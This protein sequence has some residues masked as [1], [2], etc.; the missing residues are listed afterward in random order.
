MA[1]SLDAAVVEVAL[2]DEPSRALGEG[3]R[4]DLELVVLRGDEDG[5]TDEVAD[6]MVA[7][8]VAELQPRGGRPDGAAEDLMAEADAE[9][10]DA[11]V[12]KVVA[13]GDGGR[14]IGRVAGSVG[15]D[16]A[17]GLQLIR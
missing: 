7:S 13:E 10:R 9:Q 17:M 8:V 4:V 15:E 11:P 1:Q 14:E 3:G 2:A 16:D 6:R 5:P 12:E